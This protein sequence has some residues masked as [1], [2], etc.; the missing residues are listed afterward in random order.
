M[1]VGDRF[2]DGGRF[3]KAVGGYD[4]GTVGGTG[5]SCNVFG[6]KFGCND[7]GINGGRG[8]LI[9]GD[10]PRTCVKLNSSTVEL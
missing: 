8:R 9:D 4:A 7:Y 1:I 6:R 5:G 3:G 2:G 10:K